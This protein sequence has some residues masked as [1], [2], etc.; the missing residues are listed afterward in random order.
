MRTLSTR[1]M[2]A[3]ACGV[4]VGGA[5][6]AG[7]GMALGPVVVGVVGVVDSNRLAV[8][9][10]KPAHAAGGTT[11]LHLQSIAPN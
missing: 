11:G 9:A 2:N 10:P 1:F 6:M 4:L 7:C 5:S 8:F 3:A